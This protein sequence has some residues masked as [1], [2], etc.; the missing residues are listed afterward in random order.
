MVGVALLAAACGRQVPPSVSPPEPS[1]L[2]AES[3]LRA[4][5]YERADEL[6]REMADT[7]PLTREVALARRALIAALPGTTRH[8]PDRARG[9]LA[10]L[11]A[12]FPATLMRTEVE[13]VLGMLPEIE[14][15]EGL[16]D[17]R[18][19]RIAMLERAVDD[20]RRERELLDAFVEDATPLESG[21][22]LR[23]AREDYLRL[24]GA[25][26]NSPSRRA[27]EHILFLLSQW[28]RLNASGA[29]LAQTLSQLDDEVAS[30]RQELDRLKQIDLG[31]RLPD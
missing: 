3:A 22:D 25:Y 9:F 8:D 7:T 24:L 1:F 4:G 16:A 14:R 17:E 21:F 19:E 10:R 29:D 26:P 28:E 31:R 30:L 18:G 5:Q 15:L 27:S 23:L 20:A 6:Y 12:E 11:I 13:L 2:E